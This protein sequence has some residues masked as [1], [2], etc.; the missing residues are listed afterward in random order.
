MEFKASR[1]PSIARSASLNS[2]APAGA[3]L[4]SLVEATRRALRR[5]L[6]ARWS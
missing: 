4:R 1:L 5:R 3:A 6:A 2:A